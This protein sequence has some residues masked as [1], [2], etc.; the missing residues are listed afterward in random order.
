MYYSSQK[1]YQKSNTWVLGRNIL[2]EWS[3]KNY[4]CY[5]TFEF[6]MENWFFVK[7]TI[8]F[9][10]I[11]DLKTKFNNFTVT[12]LDNKKAVNASICIDKVCNALERH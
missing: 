1:F 4:L 8:I 10:V 11:M 2:K 7:K 9:K 3:Q 12:P 5:C 6:H